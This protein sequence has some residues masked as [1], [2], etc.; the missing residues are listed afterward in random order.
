MIHKKTFTNAELNGS[1]QLAY[2]HNLNTSDLVPAWKDNT[3]VYRVIGDLI[4]IVDAN[5]ILLSCNEV[6]AGTHTLYLQYDAAGETTTGRRLFELTTTDDP[7]TTLR[8]P[9]GKA[10]T[11]T[12]NM[13]LASMLAWLLTKL[14]FLKVASNLSD[15]ASVAVARANLSVY[16]QAQVDALNALKASLYQ[17]GSG[18]VLGVANTSIY[19][20]TANY[21]PATLRNV[22]NLGMKLI[23][24]GYVSADGSW[25]TTLFL[26]TDVLDLGDISSQ[27]DSTGVYT[28]THNLGSTSYHIIANTMGT[29]GPGAKIGK[30]DRDTDDF[31]LNIYIGS[32]PYNSDFEFF[33]FQLE[34]Y[35]ADE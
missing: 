27:R 32:T 23:L 20:P 19:N 1:H 29:T 31:T 4:Q 8:I 9:L 22:K 6:I 16:S 30:L 26:N 14:G 15:L 21:H 28:I 5:N 35:T 3:G 13:T 33:M 7:V 10:S 24:A 18:S 12:V 34:T 11:A 17:A 25:T 2:T